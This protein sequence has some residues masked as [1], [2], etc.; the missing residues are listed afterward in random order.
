MADNKT[1]NKRLGKGKRLYVR[2][3]KQEAGKA[4]MVYKPGILS[5]N[6]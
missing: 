5:Y 1:K 2:R 4:G 6:S 3:M